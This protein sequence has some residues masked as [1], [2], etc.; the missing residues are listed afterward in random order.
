MTSLTLTHH[1]T[2]RMAQRGISVTDAELITLIGTEVDDGYLVRA[3]DCQQIEA[4]LKKILKRVVR[5]RGKR[6]VIANGRIV[7][8]F[9][10]S[11][12]QERKSLRYAHEFAFKDA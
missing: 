11:R 1:A 4:E 8:V 2:V 9:H 12:R 3:Q 7:T 5:L 6:L 10:A